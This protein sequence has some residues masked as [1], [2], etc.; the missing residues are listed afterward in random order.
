MSKIVELEPVIEDVELKPEELLPQSPSI[1][2][3]PFEIIRLT[4]DSDTSQMELNFE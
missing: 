4:D 1:P 3:V 2:D